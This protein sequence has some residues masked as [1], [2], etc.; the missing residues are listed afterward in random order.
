MN[1]NRASLDVSLCSDLFIDVLKN[2]APLG[3]EDAHALCKVVSLHHT[4]LTRVQ[5]SQHTVRGYLKYV[6]VVGTK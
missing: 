4:P 1:S 2:V 3:V 5:G 6:P